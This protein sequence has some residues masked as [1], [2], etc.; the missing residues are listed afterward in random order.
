MHAHVDPLNPEDA[1]ETVAVRLHVIIIGILGTYC[2]CCQGK[3]TVLE[4]AYSKFMYS[5]HIVVI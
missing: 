3:D 5:V 1:T 2:V 4:K